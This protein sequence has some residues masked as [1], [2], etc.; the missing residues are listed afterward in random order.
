[1]R[2]RRG[3]PCH[4][5]INSCIA[6]PK[7]VVV[8]QTFGNAGNV[9]DFRSLDPQ[10]G[11]AVAHALHV[12]IHHKRMAIVDAGNF[13]DSIREQKSAI[14]DRNASGCVVEVFSI[15]INEHWLDQSFFSI[16][17]SRRPLPKTRVSPV[18]SETANA[19][20]RVAAVMP[21]AAL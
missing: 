14:I 4:L 17:M 20:H 21:A 3:A 10:L 16:V 18:D 1:M 19:T 7:F 11:Q 12:L 2:P 6:V 5:D 8:E 15:Q 13:V 9:V